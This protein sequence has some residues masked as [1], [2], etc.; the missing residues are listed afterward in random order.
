[1]TSHGN[2]CYNNLNQFRWGGIYLDH[3]ANSKIKRLQEILYNQIEILDSLARSHSKIRFSNE[4]KA[5]NAALNET[6]KSYESLLRKYGD[7]LENH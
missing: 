2:I 4:I 6:I 7:L 5:L 1:M 3:V